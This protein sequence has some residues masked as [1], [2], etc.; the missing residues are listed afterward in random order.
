MHCLFLH[1]RPVHQLP[2]LI[3]TK[4]INHYLYQCLR[5]SR[6]NNYNCYKNKCYM[7]FG[8]Q[9]DHIHPM[10]S[11]ID[12]L[13][14]VLISS[15]SAIEQKKSWNWLGSHNALVSLQAMGVLTLFCLSSRHN[16]TF[17]YK[18]Q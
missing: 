14:S 18:S 4:N 3:Q 16:L 9:Q 5:N 1:E 10:Q 2:L 12:K 6:D 11:R 7:D 15:S 8:T 13:Y 17:K